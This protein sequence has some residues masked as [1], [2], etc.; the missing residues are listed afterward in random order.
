MHRG[1]PLKV[2][3]GL[4]WDS[5]AMLIEMARREIEVD[6]ITF[7]DTGG[8]KPET[9]AY[10]PIIERW[11]DRVGFPPVV[12]V[13]RNGQDATLYDECMRKAMLPSI[14][15][16]GKS[17]SLKWKVAP[18]HSYCLNKWDLGKR[19]WAAG[20]KV[21][22][23]IGLDAGPRDSCRSTYAG[24]AG[25]E[26]GKYEFWYPLQEWGI[27]REECGRI[28]TRAGLP[29]P[30][31]SSCYFC[32]SMKKREIDE[33]PG[34]L[35]AAALALEDNALPNLRTVSGLGRRFAWRDHVD[36]RDDTRAQR[37]KGKTLYE[38]R[39]AYR[40]SN[41]EI[42]G[43]VGTASTKPKARQDAIAQVER[44]IASIRAT[45]PGEPAYESS[46]LVESP[47]RL[48]RAELE[49][50]QRDWRTNVRY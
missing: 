19:T 47:S 7:A 49:Q 25:V 32:G 26:S 20:G 42:E 37:G 39:L 40:F 29:L 45:R 36:G 28:I 9:Y 43:F 4:G 8:E 46:R 38:H 6:L 44:K 2:S 35:L 41:D 22:S 15:T 14:S 1:K 27:D 11:L 18:Q 34:D 21:L 48:P 17:C 3:Y 5:T 12:V 50:V 16:G 13:K 23:A 30:P 31:K 24:G 10:L 33:L